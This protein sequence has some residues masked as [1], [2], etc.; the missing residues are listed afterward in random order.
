MK[1]Y[2]A[3]AGY[4]RFTKI[5]LM[6]Q[7]GKFAENPQMKTGA[8]LR[9]YQQENQNN[10]LAVQGLEVQ[11]GCEAHGCKQGLLHR[12][13]AGMGDGAAFSHAGGMKAPVYDTLDQVVGSLL[14]VHCMQLVGQGLDDSLDGLFA[15]IEQDATLIE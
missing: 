12:G 15:S 4:Q 14:G 5:T 1:V 11:G 13:A 8:L 10:L 6:E 9:A 7:T 2:A 3:L